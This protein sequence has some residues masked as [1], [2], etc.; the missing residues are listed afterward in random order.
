MLKRRL[1]T[2]T[3]RKY[4]VATRYARARND[5]L[6]RPGEHHA[7]DGYDYAEMQ[8]QIAERKKVGADKKRQ[9]EINDDQY[10]TEQWQKTLA[11]RK[12]I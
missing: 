11:V 12:V 3:E 2:C 1:L 6:K 10:D 7:E 8:K 4:G 9:N 5:M